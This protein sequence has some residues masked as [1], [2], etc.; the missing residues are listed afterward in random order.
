MESCLENLHLF[1][2]KEWWQR[3]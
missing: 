1:R 3:E 2:Q